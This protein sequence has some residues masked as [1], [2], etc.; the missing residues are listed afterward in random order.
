[1]PVITISRMFGSGG[2]EVAELVASALGWTL[3]DDAVINAVAA[4][5]GVAPAEVKAREERVPSLAE[6][7]VDTLSLA[8]PELAPAPA[9]GFPP[10]EGQ[11][12]EVTHHVIEEVVQA[13]PAVLVG[14]GAQCVLAERDDALHVF[15]YAP[16]AALVRRTVE[17]L[18]VSLAD[19]ERR[20]AETNRQRERYVR[21]HWDR[22][23]RDPGNY[24]VCVD[25]SW[26]GVPE[27]ASLIVRLARERLLAPRRVTRRT[28]AQ[29]R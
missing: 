23:W 2:S 28:K 1:M 21:R 3:L 19:A 10:T 5:L 7:L 25:T 27:A 17:R 29:E 11:L 16:H 26:L 4:R 8:S 22:A 6:R 15:C 12:V 20:V 9:A 24:H 13:G 14:R 18:G